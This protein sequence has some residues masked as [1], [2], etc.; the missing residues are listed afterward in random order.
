MTWKLRESVSEFGEGKVFNRGTCL[1]ATKEERR[2]TSDSWMTSNYFPCPSNCVLMQGC[3]QT[4]YE[5]LQAFKWKWFSNLVCEL[6]CCS[7]AWIIHKHTHRA[8]QYYCH[9]FSMRDD[10]C[11]FI[12]IL[13]C[14]NV[15]SQQ[16]RDGERQSNSFVC[17]SSFCRWMSPCAARLT[18][19]PWSPCAAVKQ[20]GA[21]ALLYSPRL[22]HEQSK[23][24]G[25]GA[26]S[27]QTLFY[28]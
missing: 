17:L 4:W 28:Y 19:C 9:S 11:V 13:A 24:S 26:S 1:T 6:L 21:S 3:D 8:G 7:A 14:Q 16:E 10:H 25:N 15:F 5:Q 12:S 23:A 18:G 20:D 2:E 22:P 27:S